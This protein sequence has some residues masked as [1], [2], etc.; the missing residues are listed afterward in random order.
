MIAKYTNTNM[1]FDTYRKSVHEAF[2]RFMYRASKRV[3]FQGLAP[4]IG[5]PVG[6]LD[7]DYDDEDDEAY[8]HKVVYLHLTV[9]DETRAASRGD[10]YAYGAQACG[11]ICNPAR[12]AIFDAYPL[13]AQYE[14][15]VTFVCLR[16]D[17]LHPAAGAMLETLMR[18][19]RRAV[20]AEDL[21]VLTARKAL[22]LASACEALAGAPLFF[23]SRGRVKAQVDLSA[24]DAVVD[25]EIALAPHFRMSRAIESTSYFS[26]LGD[27]EAP[28]KY[29]ADDAV[30][31]D[32]SFAKILSLHPK[33]IT[34]AVFEEDFS[35]RDSRVYVHPPFTY[36]AALDRVSRMPVVDRHVEYALFSAALDPRRNSAW[37][38]DGF[39]FRAGQ[40]DH[41]QS[42]LLACLESDDYE[43][44]SATPDA[45]FY[46]RVESA[47]W[48]WMLYRAREVADTDA[49]S[50]L[51]RLI[52]TCCE[53][54][55][56]QETLLAVCIW[57]AYAYLREAVLPPAARLLCGFTQEFD[58]ES[59][60][61]LVPPWFQ[62][63]PY[64][65]PACWRFMDASYDL[66]DRIVAQANPAL[67][68]AVLHR[69]DIVEQ[70]KTRCV[71]SLSNLAVF[72]PDEA[73]ARAMSGD[74]PRWSDAP[75]G[76]GGGSAAYDLGGLGAKGPT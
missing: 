48:W 70:L 24:L 60:R 32:P 4:S 8:V 65:T 47:V 29:E 28:D 40:P 43:P 25:V 51:M 76:G 1:N 50:P 61:S 58:A 74:E 55:Y 5:A 30:Y 54:S 27:L 38:F 33:A 21:R 13:A 15:A 16:A 56:R 53:I 22:G 23:R 59:K 11:N 52:A 73:Y 57:T 39:A 42:T 7:K 2:E 49:P 46:K 26:D 17:C 9:A 63:L 34:D 72:L 67:R 19:P 35:S 12:A 10:T 45:P 71:A 20:R 41:L 64:F 37:A 44:L 3:Q 69:C 66:Y 18:H 62:R 14:A 31:S 36:L 68:A 75:H 6:F